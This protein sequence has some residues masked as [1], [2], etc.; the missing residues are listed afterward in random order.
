MDFLDSEKNEDIDVEE[1]SYKRVKLSKQQKD[2]FASSIRAL[3]PTT[4]D[5]FPA[6]IIEAHHRIEFFVN[7]K[8][9]DAMEVCFACGQVEWRG[10]KQTPPWALYSGLESFISSIGMQAKRDWIALA[11]GDAK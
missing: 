11:S 8:L 5:A 7:D 4:Q 10:S 1:K 6:C 9:I 3:D 2:G